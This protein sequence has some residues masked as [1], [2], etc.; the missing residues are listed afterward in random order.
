MALPCG[1]SLLTAIEVNFNNI[2]RRI[3]NIP[4]RT[5]TGI[6]HCL[7]GLSSVSTWSYLALTRSLKLLVR[8]LLFQSVAS[9]Y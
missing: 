3:W 4:Q 2:L 8:A 9:G 7:A 1:K 5:H 6:H